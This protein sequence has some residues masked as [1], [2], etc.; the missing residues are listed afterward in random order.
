MA[1]DQYDNGL[2]VKMKFILW[3][4]GLIFAAGMTYT[5][6]NSNT[7]DIKENRKGISDVK[8]DV[9]LVKQGQDKI[10]FNIQTIQKDVAE[11]KTDSVIKRNEDRE[12][13]K[14]QR[15]INSKILVELGK[16]EAIKN[17]QNP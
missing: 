10:G 17:G 6:I 5:T 15:A 12:F 11:Q 2:S 16:W 7:E 3:A 9:A 1:N 4:V 8:D 13:Q 14:E